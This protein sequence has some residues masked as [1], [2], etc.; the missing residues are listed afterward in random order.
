MDVDPQDRKRK[1]DDVPPPPGPGG[2][3]RPLLASLLRVAD[4]PRVRKEE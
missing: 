1:R 3:D 4:L 2:V